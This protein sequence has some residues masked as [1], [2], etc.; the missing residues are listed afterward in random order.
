MPV[1]P[2]ASESQPAS[3]PASRGASERTATPPHAIPTPP[4][5]PNRKKSRDPNPGDAITPH[6]EQTS[7][8]W[9]LFGRREGRRTVSGF[10]VSL[11]LH[12]IVIVA[13]GLT[14]I[15]G[16]GGGG[17]LSLTAGPAEADIELDLEDFAVSMDA[18]TT[19][20][21]STASFAEADRVAIP[22]PESPVL[23]APSQSAPPIEAQFHT[24][25]TE[26]LQALAALPTG[27]GLGG[28]SPERRAALLDSEGGT[29]GS[30]AA[31]ERGLAWL[32]AHQHEDGSWWFDLTDGPCKGRCRH[33]GVVGSSTAATGLALLCFLGHGETQEAGQYQETVRRG[34]YYLQSRIKFTPKGADLQEGTMYGHAIATL[35]LTEAYG[36][37]QDPTILPLAQKA[38]DFIATAQ[39][40]DG[41]WRYSPG[42]PGDMTV[43]GWQ[44]MALQSGRLSGLQVPSPTAMSF[45]RFLDSAQNDRGSRYSYLPGAD[46]TP[47]PTAVGLLCRMYLGWSRDISPMREGAKY[48]AGLGPSRTDIYFDYYATQVLHHFGEPW[49]EEWNERQRE[50]LIRTQERAGHEA[51]SWHF[52]DEHGDQGGRLYSTAMAI[53][54]LEV[55][56]RY[57]PLYG[58]RA[59]DF[60]L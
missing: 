20:D 34:L 55:Y 24:A 39:H 22:Q 11:F 1:R 16:I 17:T 25:S 31:V 59:V 26:T 18:S 36:M 9:S 43:S 50:H 21:L 27:G 15:Q 56:Y 14:V 19:G 49:W 40:K 29:A 2:P 10:L 41:G 42:Q 48:L 52:P 54:I 46:P 45:E 6:P 47:T 38:L 33:S 13:L 60:P 58:E 44:M 37:T 12:A 4:P 35:A 23:G 3:P 57:L 51:G 7:S 53:L 28:R 5:P 32:A 8:K 30:E